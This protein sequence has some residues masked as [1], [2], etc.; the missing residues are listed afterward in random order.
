MLLNDATA[1]E[2]FSAASM[3]RLDLKAIRP[4]I[5]IRA[6]NAA[7]FRR[8]IDLNLFMSAVNGCLRADG[9][10]T[11]RTPDWLTVTKIGRPGLCERC[12]KPTNTIEC[13]ERVEPWHG[14]KAIEAARYVI[15]IPC[16]HATLLT[17][18]L[19]PA[20]AALHRR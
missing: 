3:A 8:I 10:Q 5:I 14:D 19:I 6:E 4:P 20:A 15:C 16:R 17:T 13:L 12:Q 11:W 2:Y 1:E 7:L 18:K 9:R